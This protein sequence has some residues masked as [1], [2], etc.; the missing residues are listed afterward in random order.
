MAKKIF[1]AATGQ[2]CGKTTVSVGL[3]FLA[4]QKFKRVGFIKPVGQEHLAY[5][6]VEIDKDVAM[7]VE[8][9]D[10]KD[11]LHHLSP[12]VAHRNFTREFLSGQIHLEDLEKSILE[13]DRILSEVCDLV[14]I[15]GT[16][17]GGVGSIFQLNNAR[18]AHL[19][20]APV[21]IV[22]E[23]GLGSAYDKLELN[24]ALYQKEKAQVKYVILNKLIPD[25]RE[26]ALSFMRKAFAGRGIEV[27]GGLN[28]FKLLANPNLRDIS[29]IFNKPIKGNQEDQD[30][31][32][33]NIQIGAASTQRV[34]SLLGPS[35]LIL[36]PGSR[37]E[38][39]STLSALYKIPEYRE[40]FVGFVITGLKPLSTIT[41]QILMDS[42]LPY[43][44]VHAT[45][46]TIFN[47]ITEHVTK[48][49]AEHIEK[50]KFIQQQSE[51]NPDW[52]QL[53]DSLKV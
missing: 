46:A 25:K 40:K 17:H 41:K 33:E 26:A 22:T 48:L 44:R 50:I 45:V 36:V 16:G 34:I 13:A 38:L 37:H 30:R 39:I 14:I 18:V 28:Y 15:E 29:R 20:N 53:L 12:V 5:Q 4:Q 1:I 31:I 10:I 6:G 32:I 47:E 43:I 49:K 21:V 42:Q 52:H 7:M 11:D 8:V 2:H 51:D 23:G 3:Y 9:Y 19:M 27:Y 35:T 24:I